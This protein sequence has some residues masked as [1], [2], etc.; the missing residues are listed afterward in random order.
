LG[1]IQVFECKLT[2]KKKTVALRLGGRLT[3]KSS[4]EVKRGLLKALAGKRDVV[5]ELKNVTDVD[6]SFLQLLLASSHTAAKKKK[7]FKLNG[8]LPEKFIK[9]VEDSGFS[10]NDDYM[11]VY[12][13]K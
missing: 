7:G 5:L 4:N 10:S 11:S 2:N 8:P 3:V 9:A 13:S 1:E 12:K 6:L